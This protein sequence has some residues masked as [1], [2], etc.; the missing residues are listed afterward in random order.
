MS[1]SNVSSP[2][3]SE[4]NTTNANG[5]T[6]PNAG[7]KNSTNNNYAA[8]H[9][10]IASAKR[11]RQPPTSS[12][13]SSTSLHS[14][15]EGSVPAVTS[16]STVPT[17]ATATT[18]ATTQ[19]QARPLDLN[20]TPVRRMKLSDTT[21][22][23]TVENAM[24]PMH[25]PT[26]VPP[27]IHGKE[28]DQDTSMPRTSLDMEQEV[29]EKEGGSTAS[30]T[31]KKGSWV[32]GIFSPVLNFLSSKEGEEDS[33]P[34]DEVEENARK[35]EERI[36][37]DVDGDISMVEP[38]SSEEYQTDNVSAPT[39]LPSPEP[40]A[41]STDHED[42]DDYHNYHDTNEAY[43]SPN[44]NQTEAARHEEE[45]EEDEEDEFNPYLFIKCLPAYSNVVPNPRA[46]I[47]LPPKDPTTPP[48]S[49]VLDLDETLVHC[50]V[51]PIPDADMIFPVVFNGMEYQVHVRTRPFL[52]QFLER[53][54]RKFEVIVFTASQKV[55]ANE[56]LDRIDPDGKYIRH[57]MFRESCLLVEG[58]YLKDLSVL[59]RDL[60]SSVLVDNSPHAFGYQVD[61]GI[62]IESWFDDVHDTELLKLERFLRTL[63]GVDDVRTM[64]RSK[65]QTYKLIRDAQ[66]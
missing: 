23:S 3:G 40:D 46:K 33:F 48:I 65:F 52:T 28:V 8:P 43:S 63:H 36:T 37:R 15:Q 61:N 34:H 9:T 66:L 47:C 22:P 6:T 50:T 29:I 25:P 2:Q 35:E 1:P 42:L 11:R 24:S 60:S 59:D 45:E 5:I 10:P 17:P 14:V 41:G 51:E 32:G 64:V 4:S 39:Y 27:H 19:E 49:L 30:D 31:D 58:N 18:T 56:L 21:P 54:C 38:S 12:R 16:N 7:K 44:V 26:R 55:Y 62:P 57:R 20:L 13:R 53:V